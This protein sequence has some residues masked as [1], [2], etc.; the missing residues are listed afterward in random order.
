MLEGCDRWHCLF[1]DVICKTSELMN[2]QSL[3]LGKS[4]ALLV[5]VIVVLLGVGEKRC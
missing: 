5:K 4:F 1:N 3:F 2:I